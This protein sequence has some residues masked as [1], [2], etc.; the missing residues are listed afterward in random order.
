MVVVETSKADDAYGEKD[1]Y[2]DEM[3]GAY[4]DSKAEEDNYKEHIG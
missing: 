4:P 3:E 2:D 1:E